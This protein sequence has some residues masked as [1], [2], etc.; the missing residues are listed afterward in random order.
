MAVT[1]SHL[2]KN[3]DTIVLQNKVQFP[4]LTAPIA[5]NKFVAVIYQ[6]SRGNLLAL[7]AG[8]LTPIHILTTVI[9]GHFQRSGI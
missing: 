3:E 8:L 9:K 4:N 2:N 6:I 1:G 5:L 7:P